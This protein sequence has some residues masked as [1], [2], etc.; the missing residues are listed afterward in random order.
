MDIVM[1]YIVDLFI[2]NGIAIPVATFIVGEIV[3][4]TLEQEKN[5]YIPLM[6]GIIGLLLG[7]LIP[8]IFDNADILTKAINGLALGWASTGGYETIKQ[9]TKKGE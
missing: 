2:G 5:K 9:L 1:N 8:Q 3:K 7:M 6:G 4:S